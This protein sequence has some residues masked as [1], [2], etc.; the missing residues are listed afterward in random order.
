MVARQG[1]LSAAYALQRQD[2]LE[3]ASRIELANSID[4]FENNLPVPTRFNRSKS[5]GAW[6]RKTKGLS[7]FK[8]TAMEHIDKGVALTELLQQHNIPIEILRTDRVGY[9][10]FEDQ[11]QVIAE[12]FADTPI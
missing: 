10:V 4:W 9:I 7:W 12:P 1:F 6:R 3:E 11:H 5:K 8:P 2:S